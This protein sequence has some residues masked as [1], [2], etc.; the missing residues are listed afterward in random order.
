MKDFNPLKDLKRV[1]VSQV[2]LVIALGHCK[3]SLDELD[4]DPSVWI[5]R[6]LFNE[7]NVIVNS[8]QKEFIKVLKKM[9]SNNLDKFKIELIWQNQLLCR[10]SNVFIYQRLDFSAISLKAISLV[11]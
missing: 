10:L 11:G 7:Y 5:K 3:I 9:I 2:Q 1:L 6:S 8:N 4:I